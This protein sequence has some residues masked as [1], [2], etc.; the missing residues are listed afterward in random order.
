MFDD[1]R[2]RMA[3]RG[4]NMSEMLRMQSNMVIEQTWDRDPNY[5]QVYVVKVNH[6]LPE[7]TPAHELVDVKFNVD[8]YHK[9]T[10]DEPAYLL[11]F[12]HGA[13]K[14]NP[15]IGIGSYIYMQDE[16]GEWKWW[17]IC[18]LDERPQFRQY[19]ILECNH[20]LKWIKNGKI[21]NCLAVQRYQN[22]YNSGSWPGDRTTAVDN[23]TAIWTPTNMDTVLIG[24][25]QR[26][27]ISDPMRPVPLCYTVS[28]VED[29]VP[30][31]LTKFKLTQETYNPST[32]NVELM[33]ADYW[34]SNIEP[35]VL[36]VEV[37]AKA[38]ASIVYNGTTAT[39]KVGGSYKVFTP[40]FNNAD[41]VVDKWVI[42]D[43]DG[44]ISADTEN[45]TIEYDGEKLKLKIAQ[46]YYLIKKVLIIQVIG[47]NGSTAECRMEVV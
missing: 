29:L 32:D 8:T 30:K 23:V 7:V 35:E 14:R 6:G 5:R 26:F 2:K 19:H 44:D 39:I 18:L 40:V 4:R 42:T 37:E 17:L 3:V 22:S 16:D 20:I 10:A 45:Y 28:K 27:L 24:Y 33:L 38:N 43:E 13:E 25:D 46:N 15:D 47:T 1:Y 9:V 41:E 31:G 12:R 34:A 21:Y 11:Q 36:D